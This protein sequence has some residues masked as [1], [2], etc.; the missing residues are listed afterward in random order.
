MKGHIYQRAKGTWTIVY[1]LPMASITSKRRLRKSL[2]GFSRKMIVKA[3]TLMLAKCWQ[4]VR[5]LSVGCTG[6]EPVTT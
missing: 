1:D 2:T 3:Q 5:G 4:M 6:P